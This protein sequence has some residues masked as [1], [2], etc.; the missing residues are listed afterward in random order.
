MFLPCLTQMSDWS[1]TRA[2]EGKVEWRCVRMFR[3][4]GC[5]NGSYGCWWWAWR[6]WM[7]GTRCCAAMLTAK[8]G[9]REE[10]CVEFPDRWT[11]EGMNGMTIAKAC[12]QKKPQQLPWLAAGLTENTDVLYCTSCAFLNSNFLSPGSFFFIFF[13]YLRSLSVR[14]SF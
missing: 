4:S 11:R 2:L 6:R 10:I 13:L 12:G 8:T 1:G 9:K 3:M 5:L 14:K 7:S